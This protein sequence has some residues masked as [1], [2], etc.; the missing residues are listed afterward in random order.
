[1]KDAA[2]QVPDKV[3]R[4]AVSLGEAGVA[5]LAELDGLVRDLATK[6]QLS[7]G[8][9]LSGGT[10]SFVAEATTAEGEEAVLKIAIPGVDPTA[11]ELRT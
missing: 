9:T 2:L 6:W 4:K 1:M 7:I 11:S 10:E 5:W 3:R 8:R